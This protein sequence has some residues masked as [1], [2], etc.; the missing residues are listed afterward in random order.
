[1]LTFLAYKTYHFSSKY[2]L[3]MLEDAQRLKIENKIDNYLVNVPKNTWKMLSDYFSDKEEIVVRNKRDTTQADMQLY[4]KAYFFSLGLMLLT[5]FILTRKVFIIFLVTAS[6]IS[7]A[8]GVFAPI[9]SIEVFKDLPLFGYTVFKYDF[10]SIWGSVEKLWLIDNYII[11]V[12]VALF[13]ILI[14]IIKAM[15]IYISI[16]TK[17]ELKYME[18]L[19]KW[20]MADVFVVALLITNLS[21][22]ADEFT[23]AQVQVGLYFFSSYVVLSFVASI[24]NSS[25]KKEI[26]YNNP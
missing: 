14:P 19:S 9:M 12:M 22:N 4:T 11:S 17:K 20:S 2:N 18:Y 26:A 24:L 25:H 7:W 3:E 21:L 1:M 6:L 15:T 8:V 10:K 23:N 5:Y 16:A 13:S